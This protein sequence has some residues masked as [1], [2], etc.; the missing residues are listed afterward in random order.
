MLLF[1]KREDIILRFRF[2]KHILIFG[3]FGEYIFFTI[4]MLLGLQYLGSSD[5]NIYHLYWIFICIFVAIKIIQ[6]MFGSYKKKALLFIGILSI[7][8]IFLLIFGVA[9]IKFPSSITAKYT[10]LFLAFCFPSY[11]LGIICSYSKYRLEL[12]KM[13]MNFIPIATLA[14]IINAI[15]MIDYQYMQSAGGLSRLGAGYMTVQLFSVTLCVFVGKK[16]LFNMIMPKYLNNRYRN[17]ILLLLLASQFLIIIFSASRGPIVALFVVIF[18]EIYLFGQIEKSKKH[19]YILL[20]LFIILL[21][22]ILIFKANLS[23]F[24]ASIERIKTLFTPSNSNMDV[25]SGRIY[26]YKIAIEMFMEK[27]ILGQGPL[28]YLNKSGYNS[29]P[30]NIIL[31]IL[32]DYGIIG[33][34]IM[35]VFFIQVLKGYI[36]NLKNDGTVNIVFSIFIVKLVELTFSGSFLSSGQF[37]YFAGFGVLL[38]NQNSK[39][40]NL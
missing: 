21:F 20:S 34:I 37:W 19:K 1:Y 12:G 15:R 14:L 23:M 31:E 25:S 36:K 22:F 7:I 5:S 17:T 38:L 33:F 29:Y 40:K 32:C 3:I 30:H 27:P 24:G 35:S 18:S 11:L 39:I 4:L 9:W 28:G 26:L 16:N 13:I 2:N 8:A 10:L 6:L